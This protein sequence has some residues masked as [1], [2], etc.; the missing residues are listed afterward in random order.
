MNNVLKITT[1]YTNGVSKDGWTA[2]EL[3]RQGM[4]NAR[5]LFRTYG[6]SLAGVILDVAEKTLMDQLDPNWTYTQA[7][8]NE[9]LGFADA[10]ARDAMD[11]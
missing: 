4:S 1:G 8:A 3:Y 7:E 6:G 11:H 10:E 5:A 2:I 9:I